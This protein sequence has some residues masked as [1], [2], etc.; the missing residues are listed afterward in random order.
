[1]PS[2]HH[3]G[4]TLSVRDIGPGLPPGSESTVFE[5]FHRLDGSDRNTT[6]TGLGLAIVK[7]FAEGMGLSAHAANR[8]DR[9]GADFSLEFP[10]RLLLRERPPE[11]DE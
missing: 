10:E 9:T 11:D 8:D 1:M 6:G 7:G 4:L 3:D 2:A 5:T